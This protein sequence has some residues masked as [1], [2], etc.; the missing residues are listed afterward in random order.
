MCDRIYI[1]H[2]YSHLGSHLCIACRNVCNLD[3]NGIK[4]SNVLFY[5]S[6]PRQ[7]FL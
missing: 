7:R 3:Q 4:W 6:W 5:R 1:R 2:G